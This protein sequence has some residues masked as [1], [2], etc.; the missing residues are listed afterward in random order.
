[1]RLAVLVSA[2][3]W[4]CAPSSG[5]DDS[6]PIRSLRQAGAIPI[7]EVGPPGSRLGTSLTRCPGAGF[8]AGAPGTGTAW[9]SPSGTIPPA[10]GE[11]L[12]RAVACV[13]SSTNTTEMIAGGDG[14]VRKAIS[15]TWSPALGGGDVLSMS[16]SDDPQLP[17]LLGYTGAVALANP[18]NGMQVGPIMDG[19]TDGFGAV[20]QWYR[21]AHRF[22]VTHAV[23]STVQIYDFDAAS[24]LSASYDTLTN[25]VAGFGRSLAVG[26]VLP[27][28]GDELIIGAN[29]AVFVYLYDGTGPVMRLSVNDMSFGASLTTAPHPSGLEQLFVGAPGSNK[30]YS[31]LGDAGA[32][33]F[34]AVNNERFGASLAFNSGLIAIGAPEYLSSSGAVYT[35]LLL[36]G[37]AFGEV[38]ECQVGLA[39]M[40]QQCLTGVCVGGVF[41][42][43]SA[44]A[45]V[46]CDP[47]AE[48]CSAGS[49]VEFDG[50]VIGRDGG[51]VVDD[52][53]VVLVDSG[54]SQPIDASVFFDAGT[55]DAG[56][57]GDS[58]V[59]DPED[60][61]MKRDAGLEGD[62]GV[63]P[64][65]DAGADQFDPM[66][67]TTSGC[68]ETGAL[69]M[70]ALCF[71]LLRR[72]AGQPSPRPSF[73]G[74]FASAQRS[75]SLPLLGPATALGRLRSVPKGEGG[76]CSLPFSGARN[77]VGVEPI[78]H[79]AP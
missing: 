5:S 15:G 1:M 19:G 69:P 68:S 61:G 28:T 31:Y 20:V 25:N 17:L 53:G 16:T 12:G 13:M 24:S 59:V 44:S 63:R 30:V 56:V 11:G 41:C 38:Q 50:G 65:K 75:A 62:G 74:R 7:P 77:G 57:S 27:S 42:D 2:A 32:E 55:P 8:V 49:C 70:L 79:R 18:A 37:A 22:A 6:P 3:F 72:R 67:F 47:A 36:P 9:H 43:T 71:A 73:L 4:A 14:G 54:I 39:C 10:I 52:G 33:Y 46:G 76:R 64:A 40:D 34:S 29:G 45:Q 66:I 21:G 58:G 48:F 60:A 23:G 78:E 51:L 35:E 26:N